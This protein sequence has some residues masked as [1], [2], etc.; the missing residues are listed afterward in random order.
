[1]R[2]LPAGRDGQQRQRRKGAP[3]RVL[4]LAAVAMGAAACSSPEQ[5]FD[6]YMKSGNEFLEEGKLGQANV[7]FQNALKIKE[8][9]VD[10]LIALAK[11]AEKKSNFEQ[12]YGILQKVL[13]LDP[14]NAAVKLDLAKLHLLADDTATALDQVNAVLAKEEKNAEALA[15]KSAIMFRLSNKVEAVELAKAALAI[16]PKSEEATAVLAGERIA[17]EDQEGALAILTDA[18][19]TNP[20]AAILHILRVQVLSALGRADDMDAAYKA[21][22]AEFPEDPNYRRLYATML[23]EQD[24]LDAAREQLVEVAKLLPRQRD[25]KLDLVRIDFRIGGR[26]KAEETFRKLIAENKDD[27][28][29]ELAYGAFLREQQDFPAANAAYHSI[30]GRKGVELSEVLRTKNELAALKLMENK[31]GEGE[32]IINEILAADPADPDA[33]IKRAGLKIT[34]GA[35]DDAVA[36]LRIVV[37]EHPDSA[38]AYLLTASAF[39]KKGDMALASNEYSQAVQASNKGE[40]ASNLFAKFLIRRGEIERAERVLTESIALYPTSDDNIKLLAGIRLER[41]DWRGAE[42]AANLLRNAEPG[43]EDVSRILGAAYTGLKDYAG[44][45]DVLKKEYERAPLAARPLSLLIQAYV[46]AGRNADAEAFLKETLA[47][48]PKNY[49]AQFLIGQ[50]ARINGDASAA[51]EAF[52][53]AIAL[54]PLRNEAYEALYGIQVFEGRREEAGRVI[55]QAIAAIPDNDGLQILKAD[56]LMAIG[57]NDGAITIYE[58]I[59]ARR[60][61]DLIVANNLAS[62]LGSRDDEASIKRALQAA[63]PL[64]GTEN[65][66]FLD[67]YGWALYRGGKTAEG[68]GVLEQAVKGA[69]ELADA[70]YHLGIAL[71]ESGET[72]RGRA[73]LEAAIAA[74]G[75]SA[76]IV[77]DA[78]SKLAA[79]N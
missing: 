54:D 13:R 23:I 43:D 65:P 73:E 7:Q 28:D 52:N 77:A 5:K 66:F 12:M 59:L 78:R 3:I 60:P 27:I 9:N 58:T 14:E 31:R 4:A 45:I 10:A 32:K 33:L 79:P 49:D 38:T 19:A 17:A 67:T 37:G 50:L 48:N 68:V 30:L 69:P 61:N 40:Q 63:A 71:L 41:Q 22:V 8:D 34:D 70:R 64:K 74:P 18:I 1:M 53:T 47:D 25:P 6:K 44:A 42:E 2:R 20:K 15:V 62:L 26:P 29:L 11:I 75:A 55:D 56:H 46:N 36:D 35:Y 72:E 21:L 39:E 57:E 16:D 51:I 24:K 76:E